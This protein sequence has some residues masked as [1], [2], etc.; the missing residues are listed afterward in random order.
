MDSLKIRAYHVRFG[1]AY[2]ISIPDRENGKTKLR[3]ILIDIGNAFSTE[4]GKDFVFKPV[5]DDILKEINGQPVDL[6]INTHEHMDH[7]QGLLYAHK[8]ENLSVPVDTVWLTASSEPGYYEKDWGR[9]PQPQAAGHKKKSLGTPAEQHEEMTAV[10]AE[11][12]L[13]LNSLQA[14]NEPVSPLLRAMWMNNNPRSSADCVEFLRHL[15]TADKTFYIHRESDIAGKH[16][17]TEAKIDVWGPE[18]NTAVYYK[19]FRPKTLGFTPDKQDGTVQPTTPIPPKGVDAGAF[20]RLVDWREGN[21]VEN[22]LAIDKAKNNSSIVFC[23]EWAGWRFLFPGDAEIRSWRVM[24]HFNRL[25]PVHFLKISHHLSHNGTPE[26]DLLD[27]FLPQTPADNRPRVAVASTYPNTYGGIPYRPIIDRLQKRNVPTHI[28][29]KE[30]GDFPEGEE[31][32]DYV[33]GCLEF[34]FKRDGTYG[35]MTTHTF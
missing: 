10:F 34:R 26:G 1:D 31:V 32:V 18:Y 12:D 16:P 4:G 19:K 8:N 9:E 29:A 7:I 15:T 6:Y 28:I 27:K 2:L 33:P 23:L 21:Y 30:L 25:K 11:I 17:F 5:I 14:A 24:E 22:L 3:H 35:G 13:Y 20:Y